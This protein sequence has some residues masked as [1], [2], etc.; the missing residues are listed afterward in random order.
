MMATRSLIAP[1]VCKDHT[2]LQ[3]SC[4]CSR[5]HSLDV[6]AGSSGSG[7][8]R[9]SQN[10]GVALSRSPSADSW[11]EVTREAASSEDLSDAEDGTL[12]AIAPRHEPRVRPLRLKT[13]S[14]SPGGPSSPAAPTLET[15]SQPGSCKSK[16]VRHR[17]AGDATGTSHTAGSPNNGCVEDPAAAPLRGTVAASRA[18][19]VVCGVNTDSDLLW[20]F[21]AGM[22]L[23]FMSA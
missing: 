11:L 5:T 4:S 14:I 1:H 8:M 23:Y 3:R 18:S 19:T 20:T 7:G 17:A 12:V 15:M 2:R 9:E 13:T 22:M 10:T 6:S 16:G 21:L